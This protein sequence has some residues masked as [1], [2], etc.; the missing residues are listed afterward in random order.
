MLDIAEI[1]GVC[2]CETV[3]LK[4]RSGLV[5]QA[6]VHDAILILIWCSL[7]T[8]CHFVSYLERERANSTPDLY[9]ASTPKRARSPQEE[10]KSKRLKFVMEQQLSL[11]D[12][13]KA[14]DEAPTWAK[15]L[16]DQTSKVNDEV[17][18]I[19]GQVKTIQANVE[20][21]V[22]NQSQQ[23]DVIDLKV[24][25]QVLEHEGLKSEAER[26]KGVNGKLEKDVRKYESKLNEIEQYS[27]RDCLISTGI[28][29]DNSRR[30]DTDKLILQIC[31]EKLDLNLTIEKIS[32]THR[33]ISKKNPRGI[34]KFVN[35][36]DQFDVYRAKSKLKH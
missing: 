15:L 21:Q 24:Q 13:M 25:G 19:K 9:S 12:R 36:H 16:F 28:K 32:R 20:H 8:T 18:E 11:E 5:R 2:L 27:R 10:F 23:I 26:L 22:Q 17:S 34:V 33:L 14:F 31:N 4:S 30:E 1:L 7:I 29:E 3:M 35:Y 6:A